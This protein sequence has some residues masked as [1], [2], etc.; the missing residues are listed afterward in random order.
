[1]QGRVESEYF[2]SEV[3]CDV[4]VR[5]EP[6]GPGQWTGFLRSGAERHLVV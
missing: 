3:Q 1:M 2:L 6:R 5:K 4:S